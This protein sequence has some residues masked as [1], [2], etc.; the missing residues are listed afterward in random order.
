MSEKQFNTLFQRATNV[1]SP[2]RYQRDLA[3]VGQTIPQLFKPVL[4]NR[5]GELA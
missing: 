2:Y 4:E 5:T 3:T 1:E